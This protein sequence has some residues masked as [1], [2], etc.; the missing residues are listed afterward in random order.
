M[1]MP[2]TQLKR[3]RAVSLLQVQQIKPNVWLVTGG[4]TGHGVIVLGDG[5]YKCD[6]GKQAT[7]RDDTCSHTI[8]VDMHLRP[9][10]WRALYADPNREVPSGQLPWE[11]N[12]G[13]ETVSKD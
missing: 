7:S 3:H 8:A 2:G 1:R 4:E 11:E 12:D 5:L 13:T 9:Q 6:C 10:F